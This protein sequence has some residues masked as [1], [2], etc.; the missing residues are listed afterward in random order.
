MSQENSSTLPVE[1]AIVNDIEPVDGTATIVQE[2]RETPGSRK[3]VRPKRDGYSVG[4]K[5]FLF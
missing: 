2:S 5:L 3:Q 4:I 1:A